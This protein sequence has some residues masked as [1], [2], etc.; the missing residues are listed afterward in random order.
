MTS[1]AF[2][3][4]PTQPQNTDQVEFGTVSQEE[5][6]AFEENYKV[7]QIKME[8]KITFKISDSEKE[9]REEFTEENENSLS[10]NFSDGN[11]EEIFDLDHFEKMS[12]KPIRYF[13]WNIDEDPTEKRHLRR[14]S[15]DLLLM[16][17]FQTQSGEPATPR[18]GKYH[19]QELQKTS[20]GLAPELVK[21][22][23]S[24]KRHVT[25]QSRSTSLNDPSAFDVCRSSPYSSS[26]L[27]SENNSFT[28]KTRSI[29]NLPVNKERKQETKDGMGTLRAA[30][31]LA[32]IS[33]SLMILSLFG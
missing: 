23:R 26:N 33:I 32:A 11:E 10:F 16:T 12:K 4:F 14:P 2:A 29:K 6:R 1:F 8:R 17:N 28:C 31:I 5:K 25:L 24:S 20:E 27:A 3:K 22:R 9:V 30:L 21:Q 7:E 15:I 13:S 19:S 18:F